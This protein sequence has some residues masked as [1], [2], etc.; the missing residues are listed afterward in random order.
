MN[1]VLARMEYAARITSVLQT[2]I[3]EFA[4]S[5]ALVPAV[6]EETAIQ[7]AIYFFEWLMLDP[8]V[9]EEIVEMLDSREEVHPR[10]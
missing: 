2:K 7:S 10:K 3:N 6:T 1:D 5:M 4:A 8:P 9:T